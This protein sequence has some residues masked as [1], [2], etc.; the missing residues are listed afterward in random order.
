MHRYPGYI[1]GR[2]KSYVR[3]MYIP[4][5]LIKIL[6]LPFFTNAQGLVERQYRNSSWIDMPSRGLCAHRGAM[7]THPENTLVAF[8]AAIDQGA[9]MIEFDVHLTKDRQLVV[10]HDPTV[11]RTTNGHGAVAEMSLV[12]LRNLDAGG[13]MGPQFA[14]EKI[15]TLLETLAMMPINIWLNVHLKNDRGIGS[16]VAQEIVKQQRQHQAFI[17]CTFEV[18]REARSIDPEIKICN[19]DRQSNQ[20]DYAKLTVETQADFIQLKGAITS[21]YPK[22]TEYLRENDIRINYFGTDDAEEIKLLFEYGVEFPLVNDIVR[23]I[24]VSSSLGVPRLEPLYR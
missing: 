17:A 16:L 1:P 6:L 8:Q 22:L 12:E 20:W 15:P 19:M 24:K 18:A 13:W 7:A 4:S 2:L 23:S 11:N 9:Q 3:A 21:E 5:L 10:I 14:G